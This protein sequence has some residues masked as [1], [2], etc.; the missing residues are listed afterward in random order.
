MT[1]KDIYEFV[2]KEGVNADPR[3]NS[4]VKKDL[5]RIKKT[6]QELSKKAK[7]EFDKE[8]L[9]NPYSDTRILFGRPQ[10]KVNT[11]LL[12]IDIE[13]GELLLADRLNQRGKK[14]DLVMSHHPE[15]A[16]LAAWPR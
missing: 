5:L 8:R 13:T 4:V 14:I 10:Q 3:G 2:V 1:L 7:E 12:G 11:I 16:A 9:Y 6:Y 15:G